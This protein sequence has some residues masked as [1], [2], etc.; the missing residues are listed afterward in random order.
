MSLYYDAAAVLTTAAQDGSLRSRIYNNTLGLKSKPAHIYALISETAKYDQFLKEVIDHASLLAQEPKLTPILSLL[1]VHDHLF[2]KN[3][4]AAPAAHP[5]RQ[6][7]ERHKA[8]LQ[9]EA[10]KARLRRRC[11]SLQELKQLLL[12]GK[13]S[14]QRAQP[15][16]V[17]INT[18]KSGLEH[19]L[20]TTFKGYRTDAGIAEVVVSPGAEKVLAI[21]RNIPDLIA[22]PP[23]ADMTKTQSYKDGKLI[24]QD[25]ASCFPAYM[26]IGDADT[27]ASVGE[28]IDGCAAPGNKTSH[29]AAL[30]AKENKKKNKI[31]ACERDSR[32]SNT[33]KTMMERCGADAVTLK[34][35]CDFLTLDPH[36]D[37]YNKVT[38]LLLDPSC[39]GSGILGREDIPSLAL[40][41]NPRAQQSDISRASR[42][43]RKRKRDHGGATPV[44]STTQDSNEVEE[45]REVAVDKA[46]LQKL[47]NLQT[48]IVEHA[49]CFPAAVRVTYST[50]SVHVEEN[51]AVVARILASQ[52]AKERGWHLLRRKDQT[53]GLRVWQHRGVSKS[54]MVASEAQTGGRILNE[55]ELEACIRCHPGD[56]EGT[57]GFFVCCFTR[58]ASGRADSDDAAASETTESWEGFGD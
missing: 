23:E 33:L 24:L 14:A 38:H 52:V 40:P 20:A 45:T 21:D 42:S 8:R 44:E 4:L 56:A 39:S 1:L 3:G 31:Y 53:A 46:R 47:S 57:M 17:R 43:S 13:S 19:E 26:L 15:R 29:L 55:E 34:L 48:R 11:A 22:L 27:T 10:T 30:L 36:D 41:D 37:Q 50:C 32:R 16:W 12:A 7:I 35:E 58:S 49:L 51:E 6:A 25:K 54:E 9:A 2:S 18:L 28:C 5:L